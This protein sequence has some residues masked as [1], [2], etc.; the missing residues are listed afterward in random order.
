[1][2]G[3]S[4]ELMAT[5]PPAELYARMAAGD[6]VNLVDVRTPVEF[7]RAHVAGARLIP[8]G[9]LD[10]EALLKNHR[11]GDPIFVL[12]QS[13]ERARKA[14]ERLQCAGCDDGVLV[15]G[16]T[17]AWIGAGLP[18]I[19]GEARG[20]P[21]MRQVHIAAGF[22]TAA[23]ALLA[24]LVNRWFAAVPL[25]TGCGLLFAGLTGMCGMALLLAKMPWNRAQTER[26]E[27]CAA[28]E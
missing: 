16:G 2:Q 17:Q 24:L 22:L 19:R 15:E 10:P 8:L 1:M 11:P 12:C 3:N 4:F 7:A 26:G 27:T 23:G 14:I 20:L 13:G 21:L 18:V 9:D 6:E 5:V 25:V 28:R